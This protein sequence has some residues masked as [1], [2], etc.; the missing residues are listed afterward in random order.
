MSSLPPLDPSQVDVY[1][2]THPIATPAGGAGFAAPPRMQNSL[3]SQDRNLMLAMV[4]TVT[5]NSLLKQ[6]LCDRVYSLML[7]DLR[8]TQERHTNYGGRF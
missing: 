5:E 8:R 3:S 6:K 4:K 7:E 1:P 2:S